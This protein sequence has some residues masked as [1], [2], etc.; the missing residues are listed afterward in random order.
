MSTRVYIQGL[1]SIVL[2]LAK[3]IEVVE[4]WVAVDVW[5]RDSTSCC[6]STLCHAESRGL[7]H[8]FRLFENQAWAVSRHRPKWRLVMASATY[9][10]ARPAHHYLH[11]WILAWSCATWPASLGWHEFLGFQLLH[12]WLQFA[13]SVCKQNQFLIKIFWGS[14][15]CM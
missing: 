3:I 8:G 10:S 4:R 13:S 12:K 2:I 11:H 15:N 6:I 5:V 1:S 14:S 9:G 7:G